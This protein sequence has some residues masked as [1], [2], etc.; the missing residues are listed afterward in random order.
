LAEDSDVL[1]GLYQD[2][3][4][5]GRHQEN[6]RATA[7]NVIVAISAGI[8]GLIALDSQL[9]GP[10]IPLAALMVLVGLFG[11]LLTAKHHERFWFHMERARQYRDALEK[12]LPS[13][14][15][16]ELKNAADSITRKK[17]PVLIRFDLFWLWVVLHLGIASLGA[18]LIAYIILAEHNCR[19][20]LH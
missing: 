8:L 11:A 3:R 1:W 4:G 7:T 20:T 19:L 5:E 6:Q 16:T 18:A 15:I 9:T 17:H 13:T 14:N 12:L 10:D 2:H